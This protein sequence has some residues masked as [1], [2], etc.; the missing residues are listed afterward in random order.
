MSFGN[1]YFRALA[2][3]VINRS[4]GIS[5]L[6]VGVGCVDGAAVGASLGC[7]CVV[8][9]SLLDFVVSVGGFGG[10][11]GLVFPPLLSCSRLLCS[12]YFLLPCDETM[13]NSSRS[14]SSKWDEEEDLMGTSTDSQ[15]FIHMHVHL[16]VRWGAGLVFGYADSGLPPTIWGA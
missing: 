9:P 1:E 10:F 6:G 3:N 13:K 8:G 2:L 12:S 7:A 4:V 14:N 11:P 16:L 5:L 15:R